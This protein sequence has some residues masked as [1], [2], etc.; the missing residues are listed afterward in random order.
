[1]SVTFTSFRPAALSSPVKAALWMVAACAGFAAMNAIVRHVSQTLNPL[2]VTFFRCLFGMVAMLP[3]IARGGLT[4]LRTNQ[5]WLHVARAVLALVAMILWFY[6]LSLTPLGRATA[7]SFTTPL[8]A[9]VFAVLFLGEVMRMRRWTA[10]LIGFA[11]AMIILRPG[12]EA[13]TAASLIVLAA[14]SLM[15]C[16]QILVKYLLRND[17]S[18]TVVFYLVFL[19]TPVSLIPALF[20]WETPSWE[21]LFWLIL[22]GIIATLAHQCF[23]RA[24]AGADAT[25]VLPFDFT[26]LPFA[27]ALGYIAFGEIPDLWT[28][29]GAAVIVGSSVYIARRESVMRRRAASAAPPEPAS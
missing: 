20:V 26:R 1:M 12:V 10:T 5:I 15:A 9:S 23:A 14:A 2:E 16:G 8:F 6:G 3:F 21:Q 29:I 19:L 27:A 24:F 22:L 17:S 25:A 11:G 7:L 28:W 13:M 18:N 4:V